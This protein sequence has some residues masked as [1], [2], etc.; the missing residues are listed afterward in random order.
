MIV[1]ATARQR[2][3]AFCQ[4]SALVALMVFLLAHNTAFA[5][6]DATFSSWF[7]G[8]SASQGNFLPVDQALPFSY[9]T[10]GDALILVKHPSRRRR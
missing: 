1:T 2:P 9:R 4:L 6:Q 5:Q 3:R 7:G 8:S 10:D